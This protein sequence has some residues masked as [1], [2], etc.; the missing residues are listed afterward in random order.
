MRLVCVDKD[1]LT[2]GILEARFSHIS[3]RAR[4][5]RSAEDALVMVRQSSP[6]VLITGIQ[7]EASNGYNLI[8]AIRADSNPRVAFIPIVILSY[9]SRNDYIMRGL[10]LGADDFIAKPFDLINLENDIRQLAEVPDAT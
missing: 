5:C 10:R 6:D 4:F 1:E 8:S 2:L 3:W 9:M 7:L